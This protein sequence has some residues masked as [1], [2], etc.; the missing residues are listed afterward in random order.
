MDIDIGCC[1]TRTGSSAGRVDGDPMPN[2]MQDMQ[3]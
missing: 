1:E 2:W 3:H